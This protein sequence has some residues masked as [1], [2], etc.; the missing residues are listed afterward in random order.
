MKDILKSISILILVLLILIGVPYAFIMYTEVDYNN[1]E[2][3]IFCIDG[4]EYKS[5]ANGHLIMAIDP[6]AS[7][8]KCD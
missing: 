2:Y 5:Y 7:P 1:M 3:K 4:F 8:I 6:N